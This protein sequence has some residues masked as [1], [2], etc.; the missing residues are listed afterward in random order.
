VSCTTAFLSFDRSHDYSERE[1]GELSPTRAAT[2]AGTSARTFSADP[3]RPLRLHGNQAMQAG[4]GVYLDPYID[5]NDSSYTRLQAQDFRFEDN[6]A[7]Q[8]CAIHSSTDSVLNVS[9][10][11]DIDLGGRAYSEYGAVECAAAVECNLIADHVTDNAAQQIQPG[12]TVFVDVA[13]NLNARRLALRG[14]RS[15]QLLRQTDGTF[16]TASNLLATGNQ[17]DGNPFANQGGS[18]S[19]YNATIAGNAITASYTVASNGTFKIQRSIVDQPDVSTLSLG[20]AAPISRSCRTV[21]ARATSAPTNAR[22]S[23]TSCSIAASS[24]TCGSGMS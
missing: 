24:R 23:A 9:L 6:H 21:S 12:A 2:S 3:S 1:S 7:P 15:A 22:M 17:V 10:G 5:I 11:G 14:N 16:V 20:R 8:G 13:G 19:L 18:L 4:G